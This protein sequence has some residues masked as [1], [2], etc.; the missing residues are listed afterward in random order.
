MQICPSQCFTAYLA[1]WK[2]S[3][4]MAGIQMSRTVSARHLNVG[5]NIGCK[6]RLMIRVNPRHWNV[7][8]AATHNKMTR[9]KKV[10]PW[11]T[12][13][14]FSGRV[15]LQLCLPD[16]WATLPLLFGSN[17]QYLIYQK[18]RC[19]FSVE[20]A[21]PPQLEKRVTPNATLLVVLW[22]LVCWLTAQ[23]Y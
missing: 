5:G 13:L 17:M 4:K 2:S 8:A 12:F 21:P 14:P 6:S 20:L 10:R 7:W 16:Q 9:K 1:E 15:N 22:L 11:G 3:F 23:T 18:K 19:Y